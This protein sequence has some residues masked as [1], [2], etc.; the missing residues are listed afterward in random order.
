M[1]RLSHLN[2]AFRVDASALIGSGHFMRT[3]TLADVFKREGAL[4]RFVCRHMPGYFQRLLRDRGYE[5]VVLTEP[6]GTGLIGDLAHSSWLGTSQSC[7]AT[8]TALALS[9]RRWDWL[10]VDH[11]A[12][13]C[14][15]ETPMRAQANRI[16]VIDDLADR[17]HDCDILLD[18]NLVADHEFRYV[19]KIPT[20]CR[21]LL[22]PQYALL[23]PIYAEM[24]VRARPRQQPIRRILMFFGA[25]DRDNITG[26]SIAAFL[27]LQRTEID[28]DVVLGTDNPHVNLIK[29]Q[30]AGLN[31]IHLHLGLASLAPLMA[32]ADLAIGACGATSWERLCLGLP[33]LVITLA[34]N[35]RQVAL[36]LHTENLVHWIGDKEEAHQPVIARALEI[37]LQDVSLT[38]WSCR[39]LRVCDGLGAQK[40]SKV[41]T[42]LSISI[43]S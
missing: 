24:H 11:Y 10:V 25:A 5:F 36:Y 1:P 15:W 13:D 14:R 27:Q 17:V 12:L 31:T 22:G 34:D 7:D 16:I 29:Q 38:N 23:Q 39:C 18:Q 6:G 4:V 32:A 21:A 43:S 28:V 41:M 40:V 30:V 8:E 26:R 2:V 35:Q 42:N 37:M 9:D 33:A 20:A 19:D 3:L